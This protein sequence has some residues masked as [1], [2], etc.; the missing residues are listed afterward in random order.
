[1]RMTAAL[2]ILSF[3]AAAGP[4]AAQ[5]PRPEGTA[6]DLARCAALFEVAPARPAEARAFEAAALRALGQEGL[7]G[8]AAR[9]RADQLLRR[10]RL[11]AGFLARRGADLI[12][13]SRDECLGAH[14]TVVR[15][16]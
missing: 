12:Q 2:A 11:D 13:E 1:M 7:A 5:G 15:G 9:A 10:W 6:S 16:G 8:D 14:P 3:V 4:A